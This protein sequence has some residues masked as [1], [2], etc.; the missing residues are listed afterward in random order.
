MPLIGAE[1]LQA[2][3]QWKAL[4][5]AEIVRRCGYVSSAHNGDGRLN[6]TAFFEALLDAKGLQLGHGGTVTATKRGKRIS[7]SGRSLPYHTKVQ[8]NG[9]LMVG[10]AYIDLLDAKPGDHFAIHLGR[11]SI[12]LIP[13]AE[14]GGSATPPGAEEDP[15]PVA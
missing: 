7:R 8:F 12:R 5:K 3:D 2:V 14:A 9:N 15:T 11:D 10:K 6:Y 1:L 13:L 4:P